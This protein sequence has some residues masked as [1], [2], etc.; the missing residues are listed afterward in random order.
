[1][2]LTMQEIEQGSGKSKRTDSS[3]LDAVLE[4]RDRID[5]LIRRNGRVDVFDT[6]G[7][8]LGIFAS[9]KLATDQICGR[10]G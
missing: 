2:I 3:D 5:M 7:I 4:A 9:V 10:W 6:H 1:M 8:L